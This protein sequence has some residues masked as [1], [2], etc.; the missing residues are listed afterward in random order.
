MVVVGRDPA[1]RIPQ[2][3][4][5]ERLLGDEALELRRVLVRRDREHGQA[6]G[7]ERPVQP[8]ERR[9]L[10]DAGR[11]PGRPEVDD[12]DLASQ[13]G[14]I[15]LAARERRQAEA[16]CRGARLERV[17][18]VSGELEIAE[19]HRGHDCNDCRRPEGLPHLAGGRGLRPRLARLRRALAAQTEDVVAMA[20]DAEADLRRDL[21]L[22]T[23]DLR[24][25]ELEDL[26]AGAAHEVVVVLA[27][28]DRLEARLAAQQQL[29][30]EPRLREES[31]RAVERGAADLRVAAPHDA[32]Q[33]LDRH[34]MPGPQERVEDDLALPA[35]LEAV[36][37][38]V[39]REDVLL[40]AAR[41]CRA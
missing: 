5:R 32:Q 8:L 4:Q 36:A 26:A 37:G 24:A 41:R 10:R 11:A 7:T 3:G 13:R 12:H 35:A 9:H 23:L 22:E 19:G 40:L 20:L 38:E 15:R 16:G 18:L 30:R 31:Q 28:P 14:E 33:V 39:G 1:A 27:L 6:F 29:A 21:L 34:V 25:R 2:H 17:A